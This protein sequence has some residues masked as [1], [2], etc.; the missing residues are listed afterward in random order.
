MNHHNVFPFERRAAP[1]PPTD[2]DPTQTLRT[3]RSL[4]QALAQYD[5]TEVAY[6][7]CITMLL[8]NLHDLLQAAR[9]LGKPVLF[10]DHIDLQEDASNITELVAKCRNAACHVWIKPASAQASVYRF[11][12]V[13]GY[14][15]DAGELD[16]KPLGCDY[17]DD[18]AV[19]YGRYRL[20]LK[21]HVR[22]AIDELALIHAGATPAT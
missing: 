4:M 11:C 2:F 8:I 7:A 16:G 20:Y 10:S 15:P 6:E 12:R 14:R 22:R 19:Y 13:V 21:R 18:V 5:L 1:S 3:C 17:E 9:S